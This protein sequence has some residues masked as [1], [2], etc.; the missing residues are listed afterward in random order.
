MEVHHPEKDPRPNKKQKKSIAKG[1]VTLD[2]F[3]CQVEIQSKVSVIYNKFTT[4]KLKLYIII[5][6]YF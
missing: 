2:K 3:A 1:Q 5:C 4:L 6:Y